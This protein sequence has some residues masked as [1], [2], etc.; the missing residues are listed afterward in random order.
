MTYLYNFYLRRCRSKSLYNVRSV[1]QQYRIDTQCTLQWQRHTHLGLMG[2]RSRYI[3]S[4]DR[5]HLLPGDYPNMQ[6]HSPR[7]ETLYVKNNK[8]IFM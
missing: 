2:P 5:S 4:D 6:G 1:V 8:L 7:S 3:H